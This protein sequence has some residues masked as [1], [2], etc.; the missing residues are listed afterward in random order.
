MEDVLFSGN[1]EPTLDD[2]LAEPIV[3]TLMHRDGVEEDQIRQLLKRAKPQQAT[4]KHQWITLSSDAAPI[5][6][7]SAME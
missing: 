3:R 1:R 4:A 7:S 5:T 2:I 6:I